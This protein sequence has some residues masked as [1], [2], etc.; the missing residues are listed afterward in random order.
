MITVI[1]LGIAFLVVSAVV[2]GMI[3]AAQAPMRRRIAAERRDRWEAR[4]A[5]FHSVDLD[6]DDD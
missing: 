1:A 5:E 4:Q 3:D 6:D 2:V